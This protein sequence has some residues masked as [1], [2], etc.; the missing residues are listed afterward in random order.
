M[1]QEYTKEQLEELKEKYTDIQ[2]TCCAAARQFVDGEVVFGGVGNSF[3]AVAI[4]KQIYTPNI[5]LMTEAGYVGFKGISSMVSPADNQGAKGATLH[6]GVFEMFRDMQSEL[7]DS[8]CLGFAQIDKFGNVNVSY[9]EPDIRLNGSGGGGDIASSAGRVV[10]VAKFNE[11]V[12][13]DP[14]DYLTNP[15]FLDG[16]PNARKR[17]NLIGGGPDCVVTDRGIFRFDEETKEM[18]LAEVFPWQDEADIEEVQKTIPWDLKVAGDLKIIDPPTEAEMNIITLMDPG[19]QYLEASILD[20]PIGKL[21]LQGK[22]DFAAY[23]EFTR[24]YEDKYLEAVDR[25]M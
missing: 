7:V 20:R 2:I 18:Y 3:L 24:L 25:L 12:F 5:V 1:T 23:Q 10:Y 9:V 14:V 4:S 17:A 21:F 13:K 22:N 19:K 15:G 11:R 8:A 16:S 6:Q